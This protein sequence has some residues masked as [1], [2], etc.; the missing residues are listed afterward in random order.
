MGKPARTTSMGGFTLVAI[1]IGQFM[2]PDEMSETSIS[3]GGLSL[4]GSVPRPSA[5]VR[6]AADHSG[7]VL[8]ALAKAP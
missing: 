8:D 5:I 3:H 1:Q 6:V 2:K 7:V 4:V